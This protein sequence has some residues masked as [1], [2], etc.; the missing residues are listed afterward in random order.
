MIN[1]EQFFKMPNSMLQAKV[2]PNGRVFE[3]WFEIDQ[4]GRGENTWQFG[5]EYLN[6]N[7]AVERVIEQ[8]YATAKY[9]T[10]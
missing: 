2:A 5:G 4:D 6:F 3:V 1:Q 10:N 8:A 7:E 9:E